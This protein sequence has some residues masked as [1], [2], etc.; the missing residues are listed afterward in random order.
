[1]RCSF[2]KCSVQCPYCFKTVRFVLPEETDFK[3]NY[4]WARVKQT[5]HCE[6]KTSLEAQAHNTK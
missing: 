3:N 1:M 6:T 4:P 5:I 2:V